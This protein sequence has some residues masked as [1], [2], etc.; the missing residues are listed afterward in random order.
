MFFTGPFLAFSVL[1]AIYLGIPS[2][3]FKARLAYQDMLQNWQK[4]YFWKPLDLRYQDS[5]EHC[6][7]TTFVHSG[8]PYCLLACLGRVPRIQTLAERNSKDRAAS[9]IIIYKFRQVVLCIKSGARRQQVSKTKALQFRRP[10]DFTHHSEAIR[11]LKRTLLVP[12]N[13]TNNTL[14]NRPNQLT[15]P[16]QNKTNEQSCQNGPG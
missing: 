1:S 3:N 15:R 16:P 10:A 6:P 14:P 4:R 11:L 9:Q 13:E 5:L 7:Q 2:R 12:R 8:P